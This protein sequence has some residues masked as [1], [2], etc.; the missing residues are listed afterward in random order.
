MDGGRY[1]DAEAR[2]RLLLEELEA[3]EGA[4]AL[5][6]AKALDL[7]VE[8]LWRGGKS[9]DA[10]TRELAS[11]AVAVKEERLGRD[12]PGVATSLVNLGIVCSDAGDYEGAEAAYR[13]ALAIRESALGADHPDVARVLNNLG[14]V[15]FHRGEYEK[16][17]G[18]HQRALT[19]REKALGPEHADTGTSLSNLALVSSVT[20][21]YT[22]ARPLLERAV[23]IREKA[24]GPRHPYVSTTLSDL[25]SVLFALGDYAEARSLYERALAIGEKAWDPGHPGLA[26][27][28]MGLGALSMAT[29]DYPHA[30]SFYERAL[31]LRERTHDPDHADLAESL[32]ALAGALS[33]GG[34]DAGAEALYRRALA[35]D[36]RS[37]GPKHPSTADALHD[38]GRLLW[39]RGEGGEAETFYRRALAARKEALGADHPAVASSLAGLAALW[40]ETGR[41]EAA[42]DA[43]IRAEEI[44]RRHV[45]LTLRALP[46]RV[47]LRYSALAPRGIGVALAAV[48][49]G[50]DP[51]GV[52][53]VW[54]ALVR[55]RALVM[56]EMAGRNRAV[57]KHSDT[58]FAG[59]ARGLLEAR[60]RLANLVVRG[61]DG[62]Q[63][64]RYR[65]LLDEARR[66][67]EEAERILG[68]RSAGFREDL[69]REAI[70]LAE[71]ALALPAGSAL[72]AFARYPIP[73]APMSGSRTRRP[74]A[75]YV[76]FI[77]ASRE[78]GPI[79][80]ALGSAEAIEEEARLWRREMASV[81]ATIGRGGHGA[82]RR[83]RQ[84]AGGL[85]RRIWEP[86]EP[87]LRSSSFVFLVPDGAL[88]LV[89]WAALPAGETGYLL[90]TGPVLHYLSTERDLVS[91]A[92]PREEKKSLLALGGPDYGEGPGRTAVPAGGKAGSR[93]SPAID[94]GPEAACGEFRSL[95]FAPLPGARAEAEMVLSLWQSGPTESAKGTDAALL[96]G[97]QATEARFKRDAP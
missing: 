50:L 95:R 4:G 97:L 11:R 66:E 90:E 43:A 83:Y 30:R 6:T 61:P 12:D 20:G 29:K 1:A 77:L 92:R 72:V 46:E 67:K 16:A 81:R 21:D 88:S 94:R 60:T 37:L 96:V 7:L 14:V 78:A 62:I 22:T 5:E 80:I 8:A 13:R 65:R 10:E 36:E 28:L 31:A 63:P 32:A 73:D 87:H 3:V 68:V 9:R 85:R 52:R 91:L 64:E 57:R 76:A 38:L 33:A 41:P 74:P 17:R 42:L 19:L 54:D 84:V 26:R 79:A 49:R 45:G 24:L 75:R 2:A 44:G 25:A 18:L 47:A 35:I 93:S 58:D 82:E 51:A 69:A 27:I 34:D 15:A 53:R 89:S 86:L 23:A 56:D 55:S 70:G 48:D 59:V 40:L 39:Q 71:V